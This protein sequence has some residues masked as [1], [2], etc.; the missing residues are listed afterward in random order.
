MSLT[1]VTRLLATG[2]VSTAIA[3]G[4]LASIPQ[5][6]NAAAQASTTYTCNF[7]PNGARSIPVSFAMPS[8]PST[9]LAGVPIAAQ[10]VIA[11]MSLPPGLPGLLVGAGG[12]IGATVDNLLM[13]VGYGEIPVSLAGPTAKVVNSGDGATLVISG[14]LGTVTPGAPG[15]MP[16]AFPASF[17]LG[18]LKGT[19]TALG[20]FQ[21]SQPAASKAGTVQVNKQTSK[22][23]GK[24]L[25]KV[26]SNKGAQVQVAVQ[27]QIGM[28][29]GRVYATLKGQKIGG[30][31]LRHGQAVL[32][33][34]KLGV[35]VW[36]VKLAYTGDSATNAAQKTV[37]VHVTR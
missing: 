25:G 22:L 9:A 35:G 26:K 4:G 6:A 33:L 24:V 28:P 8:M 7:G 13:T 21:C 10:P 36:K 29:L 15:A 2:A 19:N 1:H 11:S 17:N 34:A 18:L 14:V 12:S 16:I 30:A 5:T 20:S 27:R 31:K 32:Q 3:V 37:T 23:D